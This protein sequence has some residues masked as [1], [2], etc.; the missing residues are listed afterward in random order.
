MNEAIIKRL[1]EHRHS[2]YMT[3]ADFDRMQRYRPTHWKYRPW[4]FA[5][6]DSLNQQWLVIFKEK[7]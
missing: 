3:K 1:L 7:Q 6:W 4:T 5:A 2:Y